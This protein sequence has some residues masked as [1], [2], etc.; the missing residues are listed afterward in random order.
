MFLFA[1][2]PEGKSMLQTIT[3]AQESSTNISLNDEVLKIFAKMPDALKVE[4]L[5]YAEYL[6]SKGTE[7]SSGFAITSDDLPKKKYRQAGTMTGL[8]VMSDDFDEPLAEMQ[9]YMY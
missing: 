1:I 9:E 3:K 8:I 2:A 4:V 5:H 6:L 7:K